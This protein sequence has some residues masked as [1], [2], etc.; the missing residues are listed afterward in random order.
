MLCWL[1]QLCGMC[2][3]TEASGGQRTGE[4]G[5]T[6]PKK[7]LHFQ[8]FPSLNIAPFSDFFF[9]QWLKWERVHLSSS[10]ALLLC[11]TVHRARLNEAFCFLIGRLCR[12]EAAGHWAVVCA[13]LCVS[14]LATILPTAPCHTHMLTLVSLPPRS[15]DLPP[16]PP[17]PTS[18][19]RSDTGNHCF[20]RV[21]KTH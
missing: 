4:P 3:E 11:W 12:G 19:Q 1:Y 10:P 16:A 14:L 13:S 2:S 20:S 9:L 7:Y 18:T 15:R 5:K 17:H 6:T 21:L 8:N